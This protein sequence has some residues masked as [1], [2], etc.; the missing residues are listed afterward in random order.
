MG[1]LTEV[2]QSQPQVVLDPNINLPHVS[3]RGAAAKVRFAMNHISIG[4]DT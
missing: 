4:A 3:F 2:V 1:N